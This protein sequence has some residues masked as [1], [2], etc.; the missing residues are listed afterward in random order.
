MT[1]LQKCLF[2]SKQTED[3]NFL[4]W[5]FKNQI[6]ICHGSKVI[7]I[8]LKKNWLSRFQFFLTLF[9]TIPLPLYHP[10]PLPPVRVCELWAGI[11]ACTF[12]VCQIPNLVPYTWKVF[13]QNLQCKSIAI[14]FKPYL[15]KLSLL[16]QGVLNQLSFG[17]LKVSV[18][19]MFFL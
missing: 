3:L 19:R 18:R 14:I 17:R 1:V 13:I 7:L 12:L 6:K 8:T 11:T 5:R 15:G 2:L 4:I 9:Q 16:F 10:L